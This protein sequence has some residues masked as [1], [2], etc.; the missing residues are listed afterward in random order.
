LGRVGVFE[1]HRMTESDSDLILSHADEGAIRRQFRR[2]GSRSLIQELL[3][4]I[5][6][7]VTSVTEFAA[8]GGWGFFK[9][10]RQRKRHL[11]R[12]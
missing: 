4:G 11:K 7:G 12:H 9:P 5:E 1:I 6:D 2:S 10:A 3:R 8:G